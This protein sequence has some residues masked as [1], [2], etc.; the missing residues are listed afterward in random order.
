VKEL[1]REFMRG[2]KEVREILEV[3]RSVFRGLVEQT[4][5]LAN[6]DDANTAAAFAQIAADY[7]WKN[8]TGLLASPELE[9][10]LAGLGRKFFAGGPRIPESSSQI[11]PKR[12]LHVLTAAY[13]VGGH[14]RFVWRWIQ[15]D[16]ERTHSL[17]L[18][19]QRGAKVPEQLQHAV[20]AVN[21]K[22]YFLDEQRGGL[23][24]RAELLRQLSDQADM[25]MLHVHPYDV[26]P[27][28]VFSE[29][30]GRP[31]VVYVNHAD[32]V[33]S[34][35]LATSDIVANIRNSGYVTSRIR[36]GIQEDRSTILPIPLGDALRTRSRAEAKLRLGIP[37]RTV[38]L[39]SVAS[40]SKYKPISEITFYSAVLPV[41][42]RHK[43]A[44]LVLVGPEVDGQWLEAVRRF[45]GRVKI[46]GERK[47]TSVFYEAADI[48][49]DSFPFASLTSLLEAGSYGVP[50]ITFLQYSD[51]ARVLGADDIALQNCMLQATTLDAYRCKLGELIEDPARRHRLGQLTQD[52]VVESHKDRGWKSH[53]ELL[54]N[55]ARDARFASDAGLSV[56]LGATDELDEGLAR[57]HLSG[58]ISCGLEKIFRSHLGLLP[59]SMKIKK[60]RESEGVGKISFTKA[61]SSEWAY[62]RARHGLR[63]LLFG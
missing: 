15:Q 58:G 46:M 22:I 13:P 43:Q 31:P 37:D 9:Q 33:F 7:A 32:H 18:T 44:Y 35:G 20:K 24:Q 25:V 40:A 34:I 3:H 26:L 52:S 14:T 28:L 51:M 49:L 55:K 59:L 1:S 54:Y 4:K 8:P 53:L 61:L 47:N 36:R 30:R 63:T 5:I 16:A 12:I 50:L 39:L 27:I 10:I 6:G 38:M 29:K 23:L 17:A 19:G 41:L 21:G 2:T 48:Y 11:P 62:A 42:E 45:P 56:S 57:L 60:W